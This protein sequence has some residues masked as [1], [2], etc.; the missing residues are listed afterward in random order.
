M[1]PNDPNHLTHVNLIRNTGLPIKQPNQ[2]RHTTRIPPLCRSIAI[3]LQLTHLCTGQVDQELRLG[4]FSS[5]EM[6]VAVSRL[7]DASALGAMAT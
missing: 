5:S 3:P 1:L 7:E 2:T 6:A 4:L